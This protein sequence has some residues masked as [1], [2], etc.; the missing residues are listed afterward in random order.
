M[1]SVAVTPLAQR[2]PHRH[3]EVELRPGHARRESRQRLGAR[4]QFQNFRI[5]VGVAGALYDVPR[6]HV[7][8]AVDGEGEQ[9]HALLA[10]PAR[11]VR[12]ALVLLQVLQQK[13]A[14]RTE[15]RIAMANNVS[16]P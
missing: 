15:T 11:P 2:K 6:Q 5:E 4:D 14:I 8:V 12:V 7:A 16:C 10:A 1:S 9:H 3:G 13:R